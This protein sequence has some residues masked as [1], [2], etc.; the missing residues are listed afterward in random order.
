MAVL[1]IPASLQLIQEGKLK[2]LAVSA[3]KRV[4]FLPQVPTLAEPG[5]ESYEP[6]GWFGLVT[7]AGTPPEIV[8]KLNAAFVKVMKEP[9]LAAKL[10]TLGA[11]PTPSTTEAFGQ[12]IR[13]ESAK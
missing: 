3:A 2:A 8:G 5:L 4:D 7:A 12:F 1:D 13:S 11:Q 9:A 6:V 10:R